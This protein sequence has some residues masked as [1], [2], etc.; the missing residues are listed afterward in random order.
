MP[1]TTTMNVEMWPT[2]SVI[3]YDKNPRYNDDAVDAVARSIQ[4]F[5][6]CQPIVV[7]QQGIIIVGHTRHK[8]AI[9]L[10]LAEV[11]VYVAKGLT[12]TQARAYRL[13]DNKTG[14]FAEWH[15]EGLANELKQLKDLDVDLS[16]TGFRD[17]E[18]EPLL[19]AQWNPPP[20]D[21]FPEGPDGSKVKPIIVTHDQR[22]VIDRAIALIREQENHSGITE[23]QC[24]ELL[25]SNF[26]DGR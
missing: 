2:A 21:G 17:F 20:L 25:S 15:F 16:I 22:K 19:D 3:P 9:K 6:F 14:E 8:A 24:V 10:G 7:D 13:A 12:E 26:I 11:P 1:E 18:I 5:G 23:G 4:E